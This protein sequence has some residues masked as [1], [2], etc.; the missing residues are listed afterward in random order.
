MD[1][2]S[3]S[4]KSTN[5]FDDSDVSNID[6]PYADSGSSI[7][8]QSSITILLIWKN[9][10]AKKVQ[11][12]FQK[13]INSTF[14]APVSDSCRRCDEFEQKIKTE[15]SEVTLASLKLEKEL[16]LR[17]AESAR[18]GMALD[19]ELGKIAENDVTVIAFDLMSTLPTPHL[20]TGNGGS[21]VLAVDAGRES[22]LSVWQWQWGHL[23]GKVATLQ[24]ELTGAVF[25]PLDDNLMITHGKGHLT[26]WN[27]RKDG[28]FE[29][30]DII[31][32]V[33]TVL[34]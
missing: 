33:R 21:Y 24:E 7:T 32:P 15:T 9:H 2:P 8:I 12:C 14:H 25:H 10:Q 29:R 27:R 20:S 13:K 6:E 34:T 30:T 5:N 23:L 4:G 17:K 1:I 22:I 26:F 16:H 19:S 28:F 11:G 3:T 18:A 31:K